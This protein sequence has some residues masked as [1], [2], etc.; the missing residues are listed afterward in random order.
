MKKMR[1]WGYP[2]LCLCL[3]YSF[4]L[5]SCAVKH[6]GTLAEKQVARDTATCLYKLEILV[7]RVKWLSN[8]NS[9]DNEFNF[10][11][12]NIVNRTSY[13]NSRI[14][15]LSFRTNDFEQVQLLKDQLLATGIVEQ[16]KIMKVPN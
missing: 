1:I 2:G 3:V 8:T 7:A 14:F 10:L 12:Y 9:Y 11:P 16:V 13:G 6:E 5:F 4:M 15:L